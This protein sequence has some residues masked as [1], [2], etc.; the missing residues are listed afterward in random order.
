MADTT[1]SSNASNLKQWC[2]EAHAHHPNSCS[3][4][5]RYV[6]KKAGLKIPE[7]FDNM[8]ANALLDY[9]AEYWTDITGDPVKAQRLADEG[10]IVVAGK[11][12]SGHSGHVVI[13]YPGGMK[14]TG[15]YK[16]YYKK[17]DKMLMMGDVFQ[18]I[19]VSRTVEPQVLQR[20]GLLG[21]PPAELPNSGRAFHIE[22]FQAGVI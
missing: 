2:E 8:P 12:E 11:K 17:Q 10:K 6:I 22:D 13:V 20:V 7:N 4:A 1:N 5:V 21:V 16:Y 14:G 18:L 3:H 19:R 15:G 9:F